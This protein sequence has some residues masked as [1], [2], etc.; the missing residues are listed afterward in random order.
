MAL[1]LV[2]NENQFC[3]G[4]TTRF[5]RTLTDSFRSQIVLRPITKGWIVNLGLITTTVFTNLV[6]VLRLGSTTRHPFKVHSCRF[7]VNA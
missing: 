2:N 1:S 4:S 3:S 7:A 5:Q 6:P